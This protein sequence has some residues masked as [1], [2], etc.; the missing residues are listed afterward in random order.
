MRYKLL[1]LVS[2]HRVHVRIWPTW[3]VTGFEGALGGQL[4]CTKV[5]LHICQRV[6]RAHEVAYNEVQWITVR[7]SEVE[8]SQVQ[9]SE[10]CCTDVNCL[11]NLKLIHQYLHPGSLLI[12]SLVLLWS[13]SII[14]PLVYLLHLPPVTYS[15]ISTVYKPCLSFVRLRGFSSEDLRTNLL[16]KSG[17]D[18]ALSLFSYS[19]SHQ[20]M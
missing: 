12:S 14:L 16:P 6:N 15:L 17:P 5:P 8:Q 11:I 10:V 18:S 4:R 9:C 3:A 1:Q 20:H 2:C 19:I 7:W 13:L